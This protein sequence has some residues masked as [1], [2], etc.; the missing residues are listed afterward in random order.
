MKTLDIATPNDAQLD[1]VMGFAAA[2]K[3]PHPT[4]GGGLFW[5]TDHEFRAELKGI[6]VFGP[7]P[8]KALNRLRAAV[9][10][11]FAMIVSRLES[12]AWQ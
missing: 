10:V 11:R 7:T 8:E 6:T 3:G 2:I 9:A 1:A 12:E 5:A 4:M